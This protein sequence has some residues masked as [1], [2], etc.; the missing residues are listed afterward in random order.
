MERLR[1]TRCQ[2][3]PVLFSFGHRPVPSRRARQATGTCRAVQQRQPSSPHRGRFGHPGGSREHAQLA[4][5]PSE[6]SAPLGRPVWP[7]PA[8]QKP[9]TGLLR[10][11]EAVP[12][13]N[14]SRAD[15]GPAPLDVQTASTPGW[16]TRF[17]AISTAP[18]TLRRC[19]QQRSVP[20]PS[21]ERS[22]AL[23]RLGSRQT[24]RWPPASLIARITGRKDFRT[25][26]LYADESPR[27]P[28]DA[29]VIGV[30]RMRM[31][32]FCRN[33]LAAVVTNRAEC[34][35][36]FGSELRSLLGHRPHQGWARSRPYAVTYT[37]TST[38]APCTRTG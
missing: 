19:R 34:R 1:D 15:H 16:V 12:G 36:C 10:D 32:D 25:P 2:R 24:A 4:S 38:S 27:V 8:F 28:P 18:L 30:K 6:P 20:L 29:V 21:S 11:G 17:W 3:R 35:I 22:L 31:A 23:P 26:V 7:D 9:R 5:R 13:L 37:S 14:P 33:A